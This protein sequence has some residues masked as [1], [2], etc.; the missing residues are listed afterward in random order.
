MAHKKGTILN[1]CEHDWEETTPGNYACKL[2]RTDASWNIKHEM[3]FIDNVATSKHRREQDR[4]ILWTKEARVECLEGYIG[5]LSTY[6]AV[7]FTEDEDIAL[8]KYA[9]EHLIR[10]ERT[11]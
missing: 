11:L 3:H 7:N 2:C 5:A 9:A 1:K 6:R 8:M 10:L 4:V